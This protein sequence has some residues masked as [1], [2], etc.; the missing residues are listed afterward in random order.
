MGS[1]PELPPLLVRADADVTQGSGHVMRCCALVQAW[2]DRG[3]GAWFLS[4]CGNTTL[5]ARIQAAGAQFLPLS[6]DASIEFDLQST[7]ALVTELVPAFVVLDG[8]DFD[9]DYQRSLRAAG[10]RLMV[11]DDTIRLPAYD[12]DVLLNQNLGA[13]E[14]NYNS[15]SDAKLLLGPRYALLRR[16]F[17]YWRS[18]LHTVPETARKILVTLGGSDPANVSLKVIEALRQLEIARLQIRVVAGAA[19]PHITELQH[20]ATEFPG[21]LELLTAVSDMAALMA[22]SDI[23]VTGAGSTCWELACVGV[24]A[25]SLV[26]ADNQRN[27]AAALAAA[28]V[29]V[30]LGWHGDVSTERIA[31]TV[32]GLLYASFRRLRMSQQGRALVDGKGAARVAAALSKRN[33]IKAA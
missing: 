2:C 14:L 21:R 11:I 22:W 31:A 9:L 25:V 13:A 16:E 6:T 1:I 30:N 18:R 4:R 26:L 8:Y 17:A 15:N 33:C 29:I 7:L 12:V 5:R 10:Q 20:A 24:P 32:N 28:G 3:G 23:A 19:N 27:I